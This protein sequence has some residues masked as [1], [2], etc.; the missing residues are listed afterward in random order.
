VYH[1][2]VEVPE[3]HTKVPEG[4]PE[5][6]PRPIFEPKPQEPMKVGGEMLKCVFESV[7]SKV[8]V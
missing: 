3:Y 2:E 4:E 6:I 5:K 1:V 8:F 7:W